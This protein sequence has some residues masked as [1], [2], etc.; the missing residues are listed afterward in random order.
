[1]F[2]FIK[3]YVT[4]LQGIVIIIFFGEIL[5][6]IAIIKNQ[7]II[8]TFNIFIFCVILVFKLFFLLHISLHCIFFLLIIDFSPHKFLTWSKIKIKI[9]TQQPCICFNVQ[10]HRTNFTHIIFV[11][12]F[13]FLMQGDFFGVLHKGQSIII[14]CVLNSSERS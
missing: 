6:M 13:N 9:K 2:Y 4:F 12:F 1:M 7:C 3:R 5:F 14:W 11:F 10:K 8:F